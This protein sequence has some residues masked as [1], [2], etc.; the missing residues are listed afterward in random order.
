MTTP[1]A[2]LAFDRWLAEA[3]DG[4]AFALREWEDRG[5]ALL[6]CGGRFSAVKLPARL[7]HA[8]CGTDLTEI[9]RADLSGQLTGPV[10]CD[11]Y[12]SHYYALVESVPR[13]KWQ[14]Q[15]AAPYLGVGTYLGVPAT[16]RVKPPGSFWAVLPHTAG[17][18]C[19]LTSVAALVGLGQQVMA[20][21]E[22][23]Q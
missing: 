18:L 7:T 21:A 12:G 13:H 2:T 22:A 6:P 20:A 17:D 3:Q 8:A 9:L 4:P 16:H 5:V 10:I 1:R 23:E 14:H 19:S 11:A 15:A